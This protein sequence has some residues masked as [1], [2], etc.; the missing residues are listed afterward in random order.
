MLNNKR[1]LLTGG[2]GFIGTALTR[3]VIETNE[4]VILDILR[5][6]A[7]A[8]AGLD[9][10]PNVTVIKGDVCDLETV[11][12]AAEG[13]THIIHLASIA[14]VDTVLKNPV[15]TMEVA[16]KGTMN[17][18]TAGCEV[19]DFERIVDFSTSEVFG[20][21]AH[22][23][24]ESDVTELGAVGEARWTYAVSKLAT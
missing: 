21:F 14:G 3:R 13:C 15:L 16:L 19:G 5:R 22:N 10:H 4:V 24:A 6:N 8:N 1:I 2:A 20:R 17:V 23:V 9:A 12:H 7:L 11:K 18:L